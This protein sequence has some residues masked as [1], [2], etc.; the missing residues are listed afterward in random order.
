M[1]RRRSSC[2][3][4]LLSFAA[5]LTT[6]ALAL[7]AAA[8]ADVIDWRLRSSWISHV[9][10]WGGATYAVR[11]AV[12]ASAT[13]T[14]PQVGLGSGDVITY[15]GGFRSTIPAHGVDIQIED[16]SVDLATGIVSGSGWYTPLRST[17][18]TFADWRLLR[19]TGGTRFAVPGIKGWDSATPTLLVQGAILF[20]G[21]EHGYYDIGEPF[22]SMTLEGLF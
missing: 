12:Y 22:G 10:R 9:S 13:V 18:R 5:A 19:L 15:D 21:G 6:L 14:A 8:S 11:P 16:L 1:S 17:R 2:V 20:N 3:R 7:P 4:V